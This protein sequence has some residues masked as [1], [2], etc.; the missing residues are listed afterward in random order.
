MTKALTIA[1]SD[2]SS[3]AGIQADLRIFS[4]LKVYGVSAITAVTAQNTM[5]IFMIRAVDSEMVMAQIRSVLKDID[6]DAIKI[7]MVYSKEIINSIV[8]ELKDVNI[9]LILDPVFRAGTG[10]ALL[11][12]DAY[13]TF[14]KRLVPIVDVITP[15]HMEAERIS[16]VKI[17]DVD[18]A[19]IAAERI[20]SLG[21]KNVIV[22]G[23][24]IRAKYSTDVLYH[25][26]KYF[27]FTNERIKTENLHGAGCTF[28]AALTAEMAKGKNI[29]DATKRANEFV[30]YAIMTSSRIGKGSSIPSLELVIPTN[31][32]LVELYRIVSMIEDI[33]CIGTLIPETQSNIVY[34]KANAKSVDDVA[35][36]RGRIVK[37][38][39]KAKAAS[40]V[41][42]GASKHV[43]SAVLA[44]MQYDK[45][46]RSAINIKYDE[47]VISICK[48]L[49]LKISN[50]D[51]MNEPVELKSME[52]MSIQWGTEQ[53]VMKLKLI[54][55]II[56]HRG[57]W[58]KEPMMLLFGKNPFEVYNRVISIIQKLK[59]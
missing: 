22:K 11:K 24:H 29:V 45:S 14:I 18:D 17:Y 8:R 41:G 15:N 26:K 31:K 12:N 57:D 21:A 16:N 50:Y 36:V 7:G 1:G 27:E 28:S 51:R 30:R 6:I 48:N 10:K 2:T 32:L 47:Q 34:A 33:D 54:P 37:I 20:S 40:G 53:A 58:G 55:D 49:G 38:G 25:K 44:I 35:A 23:G 9:P 5:S 56:Y 43:A 46:I 13:P 39:K 19:K 42:F 4:M 3:G 59:N 52:G